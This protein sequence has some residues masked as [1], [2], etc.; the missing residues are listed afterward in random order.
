MTKNPVHLCLRFWLLY[1]V[2]LAIAPSLLGLSGCQ[3]N[4][5][6]KPAQQTEM[7]SARPVHWGYEGAEAPTHWGA[8]SPAYA[9]CGDGKAQSPVDVVATIDDSTPI[10]LFDYQKTI[11][12]IA[13]HEHVIDIVDNGHTLQV[14]V[15]EGSTL[16]TQRG[17]YQLLQFHFH[18][19]SEHTVGGLSY[20]MEAH[21]VHQSSSATF[22]VV[23]VLFEEGLPNDNLAR[24]IKHFP[25]AKGE[26]RHVPE[27]VLDLAAH[28]PS[29]H[30]AFSY[31]GSFTTPPCTE[32][33]EWFI[34]KQPVTASREQLAAFAARLA[35]NN[36]PVQPLNGRRFGLSQ[37]APKMQP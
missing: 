8:L 23:S 36:R 20:P 19:P 17:E 29:D 15:D 37:V 11:L 31:L 14:T 30:S 35:P 28:L 4:A 26:S 2:P 21:F 32:N 3:R 12:K 16:I 34:L 7:T 5:D 6:T 22:A 13:H 25:A 24:L 10:L 27:V 33:V 18:T 1:G 9:A